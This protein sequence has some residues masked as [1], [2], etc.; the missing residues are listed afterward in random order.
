MG[1][2]FGWI[3]AFCF[4]VCAVP[5]AWQSVKQKNSY[6]LSWFFLILW[7]GGETFYLAAVLS[8]FGPVGWMLFNVCANTS[9]LLVIIY[10][11]LF[12]K[13]EER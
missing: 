10:Y 3:S 11:K 7:L 2:L 9:C 13:G 12:P 8:S 5:Q 1:D 6:G 4:G